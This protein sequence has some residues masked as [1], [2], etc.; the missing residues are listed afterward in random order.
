MSDTR[1]QIA[2]ASWTEVVLCGT[3]KRILTQ[4][5]L[6]IKLSSKALK[7]EHIKNKININLM[8]P[9]IE[10]CLLLPHCGVIIQSAPLVQSSSTTYPLNKSLL[11]HWVT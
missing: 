11:I 8:I 3:S 7:R 1:G 10:R 2:L 5:Y 6:R 9:L 4:N